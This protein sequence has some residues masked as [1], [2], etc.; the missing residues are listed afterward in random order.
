MPWARQIDEGERKTVKAHVKKKWGKR[1]V[2]AQEH[3]SMVDAIAK[4]ALQLQ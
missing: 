1:N 3:N 4:D 2:L